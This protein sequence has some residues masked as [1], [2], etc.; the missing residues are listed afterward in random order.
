LYI[1]FDLAQF[2]IVPRE[3]LRPL[4]SS[5][6]HNFSGSLISFDSSPESSKTAPASQVLLPGAAELQCTFSLNDSNS[7]RFNHRSS[8]LIPPST[9]IVDRTKS[10][11]FNED[12]IPRKMS[13][14][15]ENLKPSRPAPPPPGQNSS[16]EAIDPS[17][18]KLNKSMTEFCLVDF[19]F[20][21]SG[22][23]EVTVH[24]QELVAVHSKQDLEGNPDWWLVETED[25]DIGYVPAN[26]LSSYTFV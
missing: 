21:A 14:I 22:P 1:Y 16:S 6:P 7:T 20:S 5:S 23:N 19:D 10:M 9:V 24:A 12:K 13:R 11:T 2:G 4:R 3:I 15:G 18:S 8:G 17:A 26:Y 25:G